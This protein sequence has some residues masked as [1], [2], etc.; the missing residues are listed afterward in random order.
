MAEP[1]EHQLQ[2]GILGL[3]Q[4][5]HCVRGQGFSM[6]LRWLLTNSGLTVTR[7]ECRAPHV[8]TSSLLS[9]IGQVRP[10]LF[11]GPGSEFCKAAS[12][13]TVG[14]GRVEPRHPGP[15][16]LPTSP[17]PRQASECMPDLTRKH[18]KLNPYLQLHN[19]L[20]LPSFFDF[21]ANAPDRA[22]SPACP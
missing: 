7:G 9:A 16:R 12:S 1:A 2:V 5:S 21:C 11:L 18:L 17:H 8:V 3:T 22:F 13:N 15:V 4:G 20:P 10:F 19:L 14:T 6:T